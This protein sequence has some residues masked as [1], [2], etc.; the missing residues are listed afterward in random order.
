M[1]V[2]CAELST[3]L[4]WAATFRQPNSPPIL[5]LPPQCTGGIL[6]TRS[7]G[8]LQTYAAVAH[9]STCCRWL[10]CV[11]GITCRDALARG[12][13]WCCVCWSSRTSLLPHPI[14]RR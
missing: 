7:Y 2:R 3:A 4:I 12:R 14:L 5:R 8:P 9:S 10:L 6:H 13:S 11:V 1:R